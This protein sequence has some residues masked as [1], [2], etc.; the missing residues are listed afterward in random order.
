MCVPES[1]DIAATVGLTRSIMNISNSC[2]SLGENLNLSALDYKN[3]NSIN[4][5]SGEV[6]SFPWHVSSVCVCGYGSFLL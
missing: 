3:T 6:L 4:Y 5:P 2:Q 1:S